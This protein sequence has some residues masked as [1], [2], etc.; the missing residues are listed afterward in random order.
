MAT[1]RPPPPNVVGDDR[2]DSDK[3]QEWATSTSQLLGSLFGRDSEYYG[4]FQLAFRYAGYYSDMV[5]GVAVLR[6]AWNDYSKGYLIE[7][8]SLITA[9]VFDDIL[10]QAQHLLEQ[11]YHHAAAILA[12]CVLEDTLRKMCQ[13]NGVTLPAKPKVDGMNTELAKKAVYN[14]L[15]Q[16]Q[17]T[18]LADIRNKA[19]H[20]QWSEFS[21]QDVVNMLFEV[22]RFVTDQLE[23]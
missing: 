12:G 11:G 18:W 14:T 9:E 2:V 8:K 21:G 1:Q 19:A 13:R 7:A 4:R 16:K 17:I 22:R 5:Q 6:A 15:V 20:G 23:A 10:E 3:S